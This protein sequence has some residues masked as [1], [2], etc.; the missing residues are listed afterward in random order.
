MIKHYS[1]HVY[2]VPLI[3]SIISS[4]RQLANITKYKHIPTKHC[5]NAI[6]LTLLIF[7]VHKLQI[8]PIEQTCL[9]STLR[10]ITENLY[11]VCHFNQLFLKQSFIRTYHQSGRILSFIRTYHQSRYKIYT[12]AQLNLVIAGCV[13][14]FCLQIL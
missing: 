13:T 5:Y 2:L 4:F 10:Q 14:L 11:P 3:E 8:Y 9:P 12:I 1:I 6:F 7:L